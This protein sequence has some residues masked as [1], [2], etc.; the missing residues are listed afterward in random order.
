MQGK[1]LYYKIWDQIIDNVDNNKL[2]KDS[3]NI[4]LNSDDLPLGHKFKIKN[5]TIVIK[6]VVKKMMYF[7]LKFL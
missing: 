7:I 4:R 6:A 5:M 1:K 2:I 3:K